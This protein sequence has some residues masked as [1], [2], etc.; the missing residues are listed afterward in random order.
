MRVQ[1]TAPDHVHGRKPRHPGNS[2]SR[3]R[4][5]RCPTRM[6][7]D[8]MMSVQSIPPVVRLAVAGAVFAV[9]IDY[10]LKPTVTRSLRV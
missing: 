8:P 1:R 10:F 4:P 2:H 7:S 3:A 9:A 6:E 5:N